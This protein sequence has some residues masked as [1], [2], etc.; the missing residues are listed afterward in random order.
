MAKKIKKTLQNNC[1]ELCN[2][3]YQNNLSVNSFGNASVYDD[4]EKLIYIKPS[5]LNINNLTNKNISVVNIENDKVI[6]GLKP[7]VD[8]HFHK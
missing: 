6:N 3:I 2:Q 8:Y 5:G 4:E 7:S 1:L